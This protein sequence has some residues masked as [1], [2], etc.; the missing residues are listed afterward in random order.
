M[1]LAV[2]L[3]GSS[4][5]A[6]FLMCWTQFMD[7]C[8][9]QGIQLT[10]SPAQSCNIYYVR[11]A[12][13]G[14]NCLRG[15]TQ[16]P[17]DGKLDYDFM[18]WLDSD[19]VFNSSQVQK[20]LNH[21]VDIVSGIYA[22]EGGKELACGRINDE[23]FHKL[24]CMPSYSPEELKDKTELFEVDYS[25]FGFILFKKGVFESLEYPW[26]EPHFFEYGDIRDFSMEDVSLCLKAKEKGFK[27][28]VDPTI[29]VGH[30]KKAIY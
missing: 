9:K 6:N 12:C 10:I 21:N 19:I 16:K 14:G 5:S 15:K 20:L 22:C 18:L 27:I 2:C 13:L 3:P 24:G 25:G 17:F 29:R 7:Y 28:M 11:N 8:S 23:E 4:F 1:K 30:E 26:F